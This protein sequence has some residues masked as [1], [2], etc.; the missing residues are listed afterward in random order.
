MDDGETYSE[1]RDS[2]ADDVAFYSRN[3][4]KW[5]PELLESKNSFG[6]IMSRFGIGTSNSKASPLLGAS[7]VS[8]KEEFS[9]LPQTFSLGEFGAPNG[10][11]VTP[12]NLRA[13]SFKSGSNLKLYQANSS[14]PRDFPPELYKSTESMQFP[15]NPDFMQ[16][17]N[18]PS[19]K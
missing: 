16:A 3:S 1:Q 2:M 11:Q 18:S 12:E 6:P 5:N 14:H 7:F 17:L 19:L 4:F 9:P 15:S 8:E 13:Y 10:P